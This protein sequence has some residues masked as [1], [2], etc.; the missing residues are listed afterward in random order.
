VLLPEQKILSVHYYQLELEIRRRGD[1]NF[2]THDTGYLE[3]TIDNF[4]D[5]GPNARQV[6]PT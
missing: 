6:S 3:H 1:A 2:E 5:T 4:R